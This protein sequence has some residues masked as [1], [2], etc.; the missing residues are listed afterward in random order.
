MSKKIGCYPIVHKPNWASANHTFSGKN[1]NQMLQ[2]NLSIMRPA[3][4][5]Q[6]I[7]ENL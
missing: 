3:H 4:I 6:K 1:A 5:P 2:E 7:E